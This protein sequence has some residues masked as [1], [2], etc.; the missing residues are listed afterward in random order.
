MSIQEVT[1]CL[2][3]TGSLIVLLVV[4]FLFLSSVLANRRQWPE[5]VLGAI[6]L[7]CS[8]Q[9]VIGLLWSHI[10]R[11]K[12][13]LEVLF[14]FAVALLLTLL[15]VYLR[16]HRL[17]VE[18]KP[19]S[20]S[21]GVVL[22]VILLAAFWV[23]SIHPLQTFALGQSDAYTHLH[24]LHYIV[25]QG[26]L[27]NVV[28]PSGYHW[29][30]ALPVL[31]FKID[32]YVMARF[33]GAFFG[34]ALVLAV[35]VFLR[36]LFGRRSAIFGSFCAAC[37][38]GMLLLMK[39]GVGSF[40][41]QLGLLL[42]P[43]M[44]YSYACLIRKKDLAAV[45]F[46]SAA[47]LGL[48]ASVPMMLIHVFIIIGLERCISLFQERKQ[49]LMRTG[50]VAVFCL[51]AILLIGFHFS[52]AGAGQRFQTAHVLT[53]YAE[54]NKAVTEKVLRRVNAVGNKIAGSQK[55][56]VQT[57]VQSPYL[58]LLIDYCSVKRLGFSNVYINSISLTLFALFLCCIGYGVY[59]NH[60]GFL[61]LGLWG[62][63]TSVQAGTGFLQFSSYQREG[64]SLLVATCCLS[65]MIAGWMYKY[66]GRYRLIKVGAPIAMIVSAYWTVQHPPGHPAIQSSAE[67]LIIRTVRFLAPGA[68]IAE[69]CNGNKSPL[70]SLVSQLNPSLPLT[71]VSRK[72][73]GWHNQGELVPNVL[74]PDNQVQT[75]LVNAKQRGQK[76]I[77]FARE[78]QYI[79]LV[80]KEKT[81]RP[82][83]MTSAFAMVA[84]GLVKGVLQQQ[85]FLYRANSSILKYISLLPKSEWKVNRERL[86]NNLT[87]YVVVPKNA[88]NDT[89]GK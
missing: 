64:W 46:F 2:A 28:Y 12:P 15:G 63:L 80:D 87:A 57:V 10:V 67:D 8:I 84:P 23:R 44:L 42:V 43:G 11:G 38:P 71:L 72:F 56:I 61:V 5:I 83:E 32:P 53:G 29:L 37:F 76:G 51:P 34:T 30:P 18:K 82:Q 58:R 74:P 89:P 77:S 41:N 25:D 14:F 45:L 49:W 22:F 35:Y 17:Q 31:V 26:Y 73:V 59:S 68:K 16:H 54:Q 36:N 65:G 86:S 48:A 75:L 85:K 4:P 20:R 55:K 21:V 19:E 88:V 62:G 47:G 52:Q 70:C 81:V 40:A 66:L 3:V 50:R 27:A 1:Q 6:V 7:G 60:I 78:G 39:T 79:I 69:Q 24:Y 13:F 9:A 33:S